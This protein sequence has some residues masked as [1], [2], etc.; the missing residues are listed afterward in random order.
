MKL[1]YK[2]EYNP[3]HFI[4]KDPIPKKSSA[5]VQVLSSSV[6][7][8]RLIDYPKF[9]DAS[10]FMTT[11]KKIPI[12]TAILDSSLAEIWKLSGGTITATVQ[13]TINRGIASIQDVTFI[14]KDDQGVF[15]YEFLL[16]YEPDLVILNADNANE[17]KVAQLLRVYDI[18]VLAMHVDSFLDYLSVLGDFTKILD[19]PDNY[20]EYGSKLLDQ[21]EAIQEHYENLPTQPKVLLCNAPP[22]LYSMVTEIGANLIA[23]DSSENSPDND[24][25]APIADILLDVATLE[26][27]SLFSYLPN[28]RW[29]DA[30]EYLANLLYGEISQ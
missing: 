20:V 11:I 25:T 17:M 6:K 27:S 7:T 22:F 13:E 3:Q 26:N 19:T 2:D 10:G 23:S 15:D 5:S 1:L 24:A 21:I 29:P 28:Q 12:K 9:M 4:M 30:Y 18:P 8:I 16:S 14:P